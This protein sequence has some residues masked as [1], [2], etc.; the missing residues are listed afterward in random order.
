M[1]NPVRRTTVP[2]E[3]VEGYQLKNIAISFRAAM[4]RRENRLAAAATFFRFLALTS[5]VTLFL[6]DSSLA[7]SNWIVATT[8]IVPARQAAFPIIAYVEGHVVTAYIPIENRVVN[9]MR[10]RIGVPYKKERHAMSQ[11][12]N[13]RREVLDWT[14]VF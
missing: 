4:K 13:A 10:G 6:H 12:P 14:M 1:I 2:N 7:L 8:Q 9:L 11:H 5:D 3:S